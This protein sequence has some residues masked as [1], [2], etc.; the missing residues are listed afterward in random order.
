M[1]FFLEQFPTPDFYTEIEKDGMRGPRLAL[2]ALATAPFSPQV[3]EAWW[4]SVS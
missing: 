4:L 3:T 1:M 2:P